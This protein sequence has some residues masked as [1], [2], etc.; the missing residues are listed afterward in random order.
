MSP[1]VGAAPGHAGSTAPAPAAPALV[2]AAPAFDAPAE[3]LPIPLAPPDTLPSPPAGEPAAAPVGGEWLLPPQAEAMRTPRTRGTNN[4]NSA[5][6]GT[7]GTPRGHAVRKREQIRCPSLSLGERESSTRG[8][9][10]GVKNR[11]SCGTAAPS[12]AN[13]LEQEALRRVRQSGIILMPSE[14]RARRRNARHGAC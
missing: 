14:P 7:S 6:M 10:R 3:T 5:F 12:A 2:G 11:P 1:A 9:P 8:R 13:C 4:L